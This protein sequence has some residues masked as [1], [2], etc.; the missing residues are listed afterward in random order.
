M[1][2]AGTRPSPS[3]RG[4]SAEGARVRAGSSHVYR[5]R[6][7]TRPSATLSRRERACSPQFIHIFWSTILGMKITRLVSVATFAFLFILC[8]A[9]AAQAAEIQ[10]LCSVG[11]K[12]VMDDLAPQFE[13]TSG[14]KVIVKYGLASGLKQEIE[15][16]APFDLAVLTPPLIDDLTKQGKLATGSNAVIARSGLG[17][18]IKVGSPGTELEFAL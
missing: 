13:R 11:L 7:L 5:I 3:G 16:G 12:A 10:V 9:S 18:M 6:A 15:A 8:A 4:R 1:N 14:N 17:L 2:L